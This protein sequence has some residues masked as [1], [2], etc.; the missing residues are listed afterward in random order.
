MLIERYTNDQLGNPNIA[1][2]DTYLAWSPSSG[3]YSDPVVALRFARVDQLDQ[4]R[5][6]FS[7]HAET[8]SLGDVAL[9][10]DELWYYVSENDFAQ[11]TR[12]PAHRDGRPAASRRR[13][14]DL[15]FR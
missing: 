13:P 5:T 11:R 3:T 15:R 9:W 10:R 2:N 12:I 4:P 14:H 1:I 6:L 7:Y 8:R